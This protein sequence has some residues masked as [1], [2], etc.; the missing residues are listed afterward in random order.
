VIAE[1][2]GEAVKVDVAVFQLKTMKVKIKKL[3]H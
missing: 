3:I 2:D 1:E